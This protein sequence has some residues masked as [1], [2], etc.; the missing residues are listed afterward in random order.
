MNTENNGREITMEELAMMVAK[1]FEQQGREIREF[2]QETREGFNSMDQKFVTRTE[3]NE[4]LLKLKM[5]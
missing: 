3:F 2:R 4:F 1:G 5:R